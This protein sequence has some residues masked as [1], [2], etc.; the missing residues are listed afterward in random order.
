MCGP[1]GEEAAVIKLTRLNGQPFVLNAELIRYVEQRPD[2][3]ITMLNNEK[4]IVKE[5]MDEVIGRA[6]EYRRS[7][8]VLP[9]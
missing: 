5:A 2:T 1:S 3:I 8:R 9:S 7:L 6:I 4:V